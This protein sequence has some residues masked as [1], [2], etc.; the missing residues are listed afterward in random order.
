MWDLLREAKVPADR[1]PLVLLWLMVDEQQRELERL[2]K[3][4][5]LELRGCRERLGYVPAVE[6]STEAHVRRALSRHER[7]FPCPSTLCKD[8][9]SG[10]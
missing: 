7:L 1:R 6:G 4:H 2:R 10:L 8:R 5:E 9:G 3:A